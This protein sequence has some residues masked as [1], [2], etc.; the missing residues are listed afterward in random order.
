MWGRVTDRRSYLHRAIA[1]TG[2]HKAYGRYMRRVCDE[3][4]TSTENAFT[5]PY[6]NH[7]AWLGHAACALAFRCPEDIV[8]EAWKHLS[9]EQKL[10]ANQEASR[11]IADWRRAYIQNR[12][13]C[14]D[15]GAQMLPGF[16]S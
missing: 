9:D 11:A 15:M 3:W 6:L 8:R 12:G 5:D 1:F 2:D 7:R 16:D 14:D 10:L 13:V 4:P